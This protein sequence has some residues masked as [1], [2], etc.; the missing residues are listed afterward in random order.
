[1][2]LNKETSSNLASIANIRC[3]ASFD[4]ILTDILKT[5]ELVLLNAKSK[6][7]SIGV[8]LFKLLWVRHL[9]INTFFY[10]VK[11][12]F[13]NQTREASYNRSTIWCFI[14]DHL[15]NE[16]IHI[17]FAMHSISSIVE[18]FSIAFLEVTICKFIPGTFHCVFANQILNKGLQLFFI[19]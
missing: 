9:I 2:L 4:L 19:N 5:N 15:P 1:M 7:F 10:Y 11:Q 12:G 6:C 17:L 3:N 14:C 18:H 8:Y 13:S 16:L